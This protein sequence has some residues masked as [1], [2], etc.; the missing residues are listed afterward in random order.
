M[1]NQKTGTGY[2]EQ[3]LNNYK[4]SINEDVS[5]MIPNPTP[6]TTGNP[7]PESGSVLGVADIDVGVAVDL[8]PGV[9][10]GV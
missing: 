3:K 10:V 1:K 9:A 5:K 8:E 4:I 2:L 7:K 6:I